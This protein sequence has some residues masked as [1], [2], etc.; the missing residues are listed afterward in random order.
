MTP[1]ADASMPTLLARSGAPEPMASTDA[2]A[3]ETSSAPTTEA[4]RTTIT[5]TA[6]SMVWSED[7]D[8]DPDHTLEIDLRDSGG[9]AWAQSTFYGGSLQGG[10]ML[11]PLVA[12]LALV[13]AASTSAQVPHIVGGSNVSI[14]LVPWQVSVQIGGGHFCG[15]SII[16]K[17]WVL[18]AA[19][20]LESM[21]FFEEDYFC[22]EGNIF[23]D[24]SSEESANEPADVN[25]EA[26]DSPSDNIT[27]SQS[28]NKEPPQKA[29][30]GNGMASLPLATS[31]PQAG[32]SVLV[33]GWGAM[34]EGGSAT[35]FL[36]AATVQ[37]VSLSKCR[38]CYFS[39]GLTSNMICA[40]VPSGGKDAC[41]GDSGGPLVHG[42]NLVG[43]VSFGKGCARPNYPGVYA[44]VVSLRSWITENT[45]IK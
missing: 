35:D 40:A 20:C 32:E 16:S 30:G 39:E 13:S 12:V 19:H 25:I 33:S 34:V 43:V 2:T 44:D 4:E 26:Y 21:W 31:R 23:E 5:T 14:E 11:A 27:P 18:T 6:P 29:P 17:S 37:V 45:G 22:E 42:E 8:E 3:A 1:T 24:A 7:V 38:S 10:A 36:R 28:E 15:G 9:T 41:Q